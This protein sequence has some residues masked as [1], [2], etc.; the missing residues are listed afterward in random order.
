MGNSLV[1]DHSPIPRNILFS[2]SHLLRKFYSQV[3]GVWIWVKL[4][5]LNYIQSYLL[6]FYFSC[7][8]SLHTWIG[9]NSSGL[10]VRISRVFFSS[11][12][13]QF[14]PQ[15]SHFLR[16]KT[17]FME[18]FYMLLMLI[19]ELFISLKNIYNISSFVLCI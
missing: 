8:I 10:R 7:D 16:M 11:A 19:H 3:P 17:S 13:N 1:L 4:S 18:S 2:P 6:D 15:S 9:L 12:D 5:Y 14:L